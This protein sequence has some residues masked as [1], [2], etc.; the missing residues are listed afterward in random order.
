MIKGEPKCNCSNAKSSISPSRLVKLGFA[1]KN[2][3]HDLPDSLERGEKVSNC[4]LMNLPSPEKIC[5]LAF[6][7]MGRNF[8]WPICSEN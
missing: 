1:G 2:A 7:L 8:G 5:A 4:I 6:S 3:G